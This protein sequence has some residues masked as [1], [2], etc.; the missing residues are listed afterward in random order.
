MEKKEYDQQTSNVF[1]GSLIL[2]SNMC[3]MILFAIMTN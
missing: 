3:W 2:L 1:W